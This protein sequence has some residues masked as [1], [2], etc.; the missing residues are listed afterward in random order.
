MYVDVKKK[1]KGVSFFHKAEP[2]K[3]KNCFLQTIGTNCEWRSATI[4]P[5]KNFGQNV[6]R[7]SRFGLSFPKA[8]LC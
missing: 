7:I 1:K 6:K 8:Y 4:C 5:Q 2:K 3:K